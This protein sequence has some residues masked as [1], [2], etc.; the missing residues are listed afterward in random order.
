MG[1]R[2]LAIETLKDPSNIGVSFITVSFLFPSL[3]LLPTCPETPPNVEIYPTKKNIGTFFVTSTD[4]MM[5][6]QISNFVD[7]NDFPAYVKAEHGEVS[8]KYWHW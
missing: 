7:N 2:A 5:R 8:L 1:L 6:F 3:Y 4:D